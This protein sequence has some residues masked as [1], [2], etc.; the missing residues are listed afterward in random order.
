M[1]PGPHQLARLAGQQAKGLFLS[2]LHAG[3]AGVCPYLVGF[4]GLFL[5]LFFTWVLD[6]SSGPHA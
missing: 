2:C 5:F 1:E 3:T 4:F 6:P